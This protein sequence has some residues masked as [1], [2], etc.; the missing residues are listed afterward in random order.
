[1]PEE[2]EEVEVEEDEQESRPRRKKKVSIKQQADAVAAVVDVKSNYKTYSTLQIARLNR[3]YAAVRTFEGVK[4]AAWANAFKVNKAFEIE[5]KITSRLTANNPKFIATLEET[6]TEIADRYYPVKEG[7]TDP[8]VLEERAKFEA[9]IAGWNKAIQTYLNN[10]FALRDFSLAIRRAAKTLVRYGN[11]YGTIDYKVQEYRYIEKDGTIKRKTG[12]EIPVL[13]SMS[14]TDILVDP[15]FHETE[16]SPGVIWRHEN[17]RLAELLAQD[18]ELIN[19]D[20]IKNQPASQTSNEKQWIYSIV[21]PGASTAGD[22]TIKAKS[23]TVDKFY[24]YYSPTGKP[25]D[26]GIYE[27]WTV[28]DALCIKF[29]EIR[30]IPIISCVC[31]DDPEQH[32]G[33]G[34]LEPM[35]GLQEEADFKRNAAN[36]YINQSLY[37][38]W[39]LDAQSGID[40]KQLIGAAPNALIMTS[41]IA[42]EVLGQHLV[43]VPHRPIPSEYFSIS[44]EINRDIQS[45]S[46]TIDTTTTS[47]QQGFTNTATG[48]RIRAFETNTVYADILRHFETWLEKL[49]YQM[50]EELRYNMHEDIILEYMGDNSKILLKK[51]MLEDV[52]LRYTIKVEAGSSS[53]DTIEARRDDAI[54]LGT[55]AEQFKKSGS[56][57]NMDSI[58]EKAFSTFEGVDVSK[59]L[60]KNKESLDMLMGGMAQPGGAPKFPS[61]DLSPA[62][63]LDNPQEL[64]D[65]VVSG[66]M[67]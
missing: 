66:K 51:I 61:G 58:A 26:E 50:L 23:L 16:N 67:I 52:P 11:V 37:R 49:A 29:Q 18:D 15:R 47:S 62:P 63:S 4:R 59:I 65:A 20:K 53:Y 35:L 8:A 31:F 1:M 64:T 12:K 13:T 38:S 7:E 5:N 3:I 39:I 41:G 6:P 54:A 43:E 46:F 48:Q 14:F 24:G 40:P 44:N 27:I 10:A 17:V 2:I 55:L 28:N 21:I 56:N 25:E 57:V 32:Y 45:V 9:D 30:E 36:D 60:N 42:G 34:F 19:L 33:V 22:A